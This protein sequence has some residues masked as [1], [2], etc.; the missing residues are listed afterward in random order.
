[1]TTLTLTAPAKV[2]L[3]LA[4]HERRPD[5][6]HRLT[7]LFERLD[8]AD[9]LTLTRRSSEI[10]VTCDDSSVPTDGRNLVWR[11][12][13]A[14]FAAAGIDGG[15]EAHLAKRIPVAAGLGG[16]SSDAAATLLGLNQLYGHPVSPEPLMA[17]GRGLG[18]DVPFFL[19]EIPLAWGRGRGDEITPIVPPRAPLW[20]VLVHPRVP[21]LTREVY[22]T[23]DRLA[24]TDSGLTALEE[25]GIL[26]ERSVQSGGVAEVAARLVNALEPAIEAS[27][28]AIRGLKAALRQAGA[29]GVLV[30][31]S[32]STAFGLARDESDAESIVGQLRRA[33]PQWTVLSARTALA[34]P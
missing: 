29:L 15:V 8:L 11:A 16:G 28:P 34:L 33:Y 6:Y 2:N 25:D 27:Y 30:S 13:E 24:A 32:G 21:I 18:A 26:L 4:V 20:H 14:F 3:Y 17:L 10:R 9:T 19:S 12:A 22:A 1:M 31:G 7:T 23:F 5:G